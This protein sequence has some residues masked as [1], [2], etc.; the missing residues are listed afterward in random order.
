MSPDTDRDQMRMECAF[1]QRDSLEAIL[2][3]TSQFF[4]LAD[5]AP[6]VEGHLLIVPKRHFACYGAVPREH[7]E[8]LLAI[9]RRVSDFFGAVY[10]APVFFEHGVFHQTVY[11]AHLHAFP[12]GRVELGLHLLAATDGRPVMSQADLRTWYA[13]RGHYFYLEQPPAPG[14]SVE[15]A[16]FPPVESRYF[17]VLGQLRARS[18][19]PGGWQPQ[20]VR[21]VTGKA[22]MRALIE[23]WQRYAAAM[24]P[25]ELSSAS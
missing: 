3:E 5:H 10:S 24:P 7:D 14:A 18:G 21:R 23:R 9:K 6:L 2:M 25:D 12:F 4:V 20:V 19:V 22:H 11:H 13:E 1:C 16:I 8:E 17:A 15:A